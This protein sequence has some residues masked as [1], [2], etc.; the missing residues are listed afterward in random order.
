MKT[1]SKCHG[2]P[3]DRYCSP[4]CGLR[5]VVLPVRRRKMETPAPLPVEVPVTEERPVKWPRYRCVECR[6]WRMDSPEPREYCF[7]C[8]P[9]KNPEVDAM[10]AAHRERKRLAKVE[11]E[12][13][14][15][16]PK[17]F[18]STAMER[19]EEFMRNRDA[20]YIPPVRKVCSVPHCRALY[21]TICDRCTHLHIDRLKREGMPYTTDCWPKPV[22][23]HPEFM[24]TFFA[25]DR[26]K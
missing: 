22:E 19:R 2:K 13:K 21:V 15:S 6:R 18:S 10:L 5:K 11:A 12:Q 9:G 3:G 16:T 26:S 14:K 25:L 17:L 4:R 1:C 7:S 23:T 8:E 24:P 20:G